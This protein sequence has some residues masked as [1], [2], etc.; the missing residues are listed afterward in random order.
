MLALMEIFSKQ[1]GIHRV[2]VYGSRAMGRY[3]EG[4][5]IDIVLDAPKL[6][7]SDSSALMISLSDSMIPQE[8]DLALLHEVTN[9]DLLS[10]IERVGVVVFE[11]GL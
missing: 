1:A 10:H 11:G 5:D 6:L 8:V 2:I 3:R 4:S 7:F 9:A